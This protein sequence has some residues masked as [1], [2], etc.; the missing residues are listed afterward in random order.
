MKKMLLSGPMVAI[1]QKKKTFE[2]S[3]LRVER[4]GGKEYQTYNEGTD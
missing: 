3:P 4:D 1:E 2:L